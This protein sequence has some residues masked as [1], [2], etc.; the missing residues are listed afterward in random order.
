MSDNSNTSHIVYSFFSSALTCYQKAQ[1]ETDTDIEVDKFLF[2]Y[3]DRCIA[4]YK[5]EF[6]DIEDSSK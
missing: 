4:L 2:N 5:L 3:I 6:E 1:L